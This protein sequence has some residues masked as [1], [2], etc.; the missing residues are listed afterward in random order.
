M[1]MLLKEAV[2]FLRDK[3][4]MGKRLA[5]FR[6]AG[7]SSCVKSK[8]SAS[9]MIWLRRNISIFKDDESKN[10]IGKCREGASGEV[11]A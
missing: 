10:V 8:L 9:K 4:G 11:E 6:C 5:N 2:P 3:G 1:M 7:G